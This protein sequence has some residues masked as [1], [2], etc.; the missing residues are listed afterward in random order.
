MR[1]TMRV[2]LTMLALMTAN[3]TFGA[4]YLNTYIGLE[5]GLSIFSFEEKIDQQLVFPMAN[6]TGGIAWERFTLAGTLSG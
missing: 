6:L 4:P 1:N 5:G 3:Q 2:G